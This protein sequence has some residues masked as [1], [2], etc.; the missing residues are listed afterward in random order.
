MFQTKHVGGT[1][2][3]YNYK[4]VGSTFLFHFQISRCNIVV[5]NLYFNECERKKY[6]FGINAYN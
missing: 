6:C 3:F 4:M 1:M 2:K 5:Y